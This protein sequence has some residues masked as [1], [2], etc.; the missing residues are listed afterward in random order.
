MAFAP[1]PVRYP[2]PPLAM[3]PPVVDMWSHMGHIGGNV[4]FCI[5]PACTNPID[6]DDL[7]AVQ[8]DLMPTNPSWIKTANP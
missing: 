2:P 3:G 8:H 4:T 7:S 6:Q 5:T 1:V